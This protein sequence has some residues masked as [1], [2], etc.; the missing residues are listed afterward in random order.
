[1]GYFRPIVACGKTKE[2]IATSTV[3]A[4]D[5]VIDCDNASNAYAVG[6]PVF[7]SKSDD[8]GNEFMGEVTQ[9]MA[10]E[11]TVELTV[12]TSKGA[13][14]KLWMPAASYRF[15]SGYGFH[16]KPVEYLGVVTDRSRG[17][18]FYATQIAD[19]VSGVIMR[20][21]GG[22]PADWQGY[23]TFL[24]TNRDNGRKPFSLAWWDHFAGVTRVCD[25]I[26]KSNRVDDVSAVLMAELVESEKARFD[27]EHYIQASDS[28]V[29]T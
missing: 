11:I 1:M 22:K 29:S 28:Y 2:K 8:A 27:F 21:D 4:G 7:I 3:L 17:G 26:L 24:K 15:E 14:A 23:V 12:G 9:A 25:V 6:D 5:V 18:Q 13:G 19:S 20:W 10:S 16:M